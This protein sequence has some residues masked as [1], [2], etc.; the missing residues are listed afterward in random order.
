MVLK[1]LVYCSPDILTNG[2]P[3]TITIIDDDDEGAKL[4]ED[5]RNNIRHNMIV[6]D[7]I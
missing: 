1:G 6:C 5:T 3:F 2:K 4:V 7:M